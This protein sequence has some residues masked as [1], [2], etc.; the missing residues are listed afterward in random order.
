M[1][2]LVVHSVQ[3]QSFLLRGI[4]ATTSCGIPRSPGIPKNNLHKICTET[5]Q[6]HSPFPSRAH[7]L[8]QSAGFRGSFRGGLQISGS[9]ISMVEYA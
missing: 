7:K 2:S 8:G 9:L 4:A 6:A 3:I 5:Q 1:V